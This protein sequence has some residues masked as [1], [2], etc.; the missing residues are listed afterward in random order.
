MLATVAVVI[1]IIIIIFIEKE[2]FIFQQKIDPALP[3]HMQPN[4]PSPGAFSSHSKS[5]WSFSRQA[6][7]S[8]MWC[9]QGDYLKQGCWRRTLWGGG[10]W[11]SS[12]AKAMFAEMH[13]RQ[14]GRACAQSLMWVLFVPS[15]GKGHGDRKTAHEFWEW[16]RGRLQQVFWL[17]SVRDG[18]LPEIAE[19]GCS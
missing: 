18:K 6:D 17:H 14:G 1:I 3:H 4:V 13:S 15:G 5:Q 7:P 16:A 12:E 9:Y 2:K 10:I 8:F 11:E 19:S